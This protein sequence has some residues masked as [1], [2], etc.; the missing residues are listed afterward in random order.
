MATVHVD[1]V[2]GN[3]A[4]KSADGYTFDRMAKVTG[5]TGNAH[6]MIYAA[7]NAN[8]VPWIGSSHPD[9][10]LALLRSIDATSVSGNTVEL[11]LHYSTK[12][13]S[14]GSGSQYPVPSMATIQC[15]ASVMQEQ[16]SKDI[17]GNPY[18]MSY[19][20]PNVYPKDVGLQGK[21]ALQA[22]TL[23]KYIP[24]ISMRIQKLESISGV[25]LNAR[26]KEYV[27]KVN[28]TSW[29][30]DPTAEAKEW[31][32][33]GIFGVS[34]D[35]GTTYTVT[36][37]FQYKPGGWF[38]TAVYMDR[39]TGSPLVK[40]DGDIVWQDFKNL[41]AQVDFTSLGLA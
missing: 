30:L 13:P 8:G 39:T 15:G 21:T 34:A 18:R 16:V 26:A 28:S 20:F 33:T 19:T 40:E 5:L 10:G 32:C 14:S 24:L 22:A 12:E 1:L 38:G 29:P 2:D 7:M 6:A 27:G 35:S 36:Y 25:V 37:E 4:Q 17:E 3:S 9:V 23:T 41:Y 31:L 11:K